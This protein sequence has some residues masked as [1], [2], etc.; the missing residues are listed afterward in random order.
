MSSNGCSPIMTIVF[1]VFLVESYLICMQ[2][3]LLQV[4][5]QTIRLSASSKTITYW[6][7]RIDW[8][9]FNLSKISKMPRNLKFRKKCGWH[10]LDERQTWKPRTQAIFGPARPVI[11]TANKIHGKSTLMESCGILRLVVLFSY[12]PNKPIEMQR[13][14]LNFSLHDSL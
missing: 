14:R 1:M 3:K 13:I 7:I 2:L 10:R 11:S 8:S 6:F 4:D 12:L 9:N 5:G